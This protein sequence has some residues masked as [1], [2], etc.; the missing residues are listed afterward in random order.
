MMNPNSSHQTWSRWRATVTVPFDRTHTTDAF[1]EEMKTACG[2]FYKKLLGSATAL[3]IDRQLSLIR[4]ESRFI[5]EART[6]GPP[7]QD[8]RFRRLQC[9]QI[10]A[11]FGRN[12]RH[13]CKDGEKVRVHVDVYLEAGDPGDGRPPS[14]LIIAPGIP[15]PEWFKKRFKKKGA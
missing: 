7:V 5:V 1:A 3:K 13:Y 14:Q 11:F 4:A 12:L 15:L 10:G 6:E 9:D 2:R 8:P